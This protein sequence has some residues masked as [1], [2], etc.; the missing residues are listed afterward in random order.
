MAT[1]PKVRR[2]TVSLDPAEYAELKRIAESHRPPL[3]M[4][5]V[6]RYALQKFL[7]EHKGKQLSLDI[8]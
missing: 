7:D 6:V 1:K 8:G 5:I 4:Q 3:S 2:F